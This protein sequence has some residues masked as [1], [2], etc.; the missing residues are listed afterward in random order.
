M[1]DKRAALRQQVTT[2]KIRDAI[3]QKKIRSSKVNQH[4]SEERNLISVS[5]AWT[6]LGLT[7][8]NAVNRVIRN[9][10]DKG[11]WPSD[12]KEKFVWYLSGT[13]AL[14]VDPV[15]VHGNHLEVF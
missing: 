12:R 5:G 10:F 3:H 1:R 6:H 9:T 13:A 8:Q 14:A 4:H 11:L 7:D 15:P 2:S